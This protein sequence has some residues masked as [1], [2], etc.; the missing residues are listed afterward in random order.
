MQATWKD[1][2]ERFI[3]ALTS[4]AIAVVLDVLEPGHV[5]G[6]AEGN[7]AALLHRI[8][9]QIARQ[10]QVEDLRPQA[11]CRRPNPP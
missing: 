10:R 2:H 7:P 4:L 5:V 8:G 9:L 11:R 6:Q 3:R 1:S